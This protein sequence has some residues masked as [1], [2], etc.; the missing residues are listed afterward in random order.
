MLIAG[1]HG[2]YRVAVRQKI[3][4]LLDGRTGRML[5]IPFASSDSTHC[6]RERTG[7]VLG[8]FRQE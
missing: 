8:G 5:M 1:S 6:V 3:M 2:F 4:E 7:A